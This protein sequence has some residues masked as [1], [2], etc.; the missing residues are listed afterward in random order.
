MTTTKQSP[1]LEKQSKDSK[2][3]KSER[4]KDLKLNLIHALFIHGT[5]SELYHDSIDH[6]F[7]NFVHDIIYVH[8]LAI[9]SS[10]N[11]ELKNKMNY[12]PFNPEKNETEQKTTKQNKKKVNT[13]KQKKK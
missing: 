2:T 12:K 5:F 13:Q 8:E 1:D 10:D 9:E 7:K 4:P 11:D 6:Q 3:P